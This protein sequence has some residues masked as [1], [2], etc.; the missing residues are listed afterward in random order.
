MRNRIYPMALLAVACL[1]FLPETAQA[2]RVYVVRKPNGQVQIVDP[3]NTMMRRIL[4]MPMRVLGVTKKA[5]RKPEGFGRAI[6]QR[7][8]ATPAKTSDAVKDSVGGALNAAVDGTGQVMHRVHSA[9][10]VAVKAAAAAA[11]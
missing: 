2:R 7:D 3:Q 8:M 11:Y 6:T 4:R 9:S 10:G 1:M 5:V